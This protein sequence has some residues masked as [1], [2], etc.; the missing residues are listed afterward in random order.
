[1]VEV[2][3][4]EAQALLHERFHQWSKELHRPSNLEDL[5]HL[6]QRSIH[7]KI[8]VLINIVN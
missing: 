7:A 1:M 4:W 6:L 8:M 5:G 2:E 3:I